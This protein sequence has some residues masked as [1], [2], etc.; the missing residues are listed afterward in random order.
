[1]RINY[2]QHQFFQQDF[3]K[4]AKFCSQKQLDIL[5]S[6]QFPSGHFPYSTMFSSDLRKQN[7]IINFLWN[8][9]PSRTCVQQKYNKSIYTPRIRNF[10][11]KK[12]SIPKLTNSYPLGLNP[13]WMKTNLF[14]FS[15]KLSET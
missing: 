8:S 14:L 13:V 12:S 1:M 3:D 4:A 7:S 5:R 2:R 6:S 11:Y 9:T 15:E 10:T